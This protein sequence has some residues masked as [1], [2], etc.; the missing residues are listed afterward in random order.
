MKHRSKIG[1]GVGLAALLLAAMAAPHALATEPS[2]VVVAKYDRDSDKTLDWNEVETAA[3]AHFAKLDQ[4]ADATLSRREAKAVMGAVS[5]KAADTDH[6]GT[7]SKSEYVAV[8][9]KHFDHA[10][11]DKDGTLS[12]KELSSSAGHKLKLLID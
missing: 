7:L 11:T 1:F 10:D 2:S 8:V 9:K 6:D 12:A 5:F 3:N 4:D